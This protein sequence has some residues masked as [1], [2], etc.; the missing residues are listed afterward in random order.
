MAGF[1]RTLEIRSHRRVREAGAGEPLPDPLHLGAGQRRFRVTGATLVDQD[2][3]AVVSLGAGGESRI[4]RGVSEVDAKSE[5][6]VGCRVAT[7]GLDPGD[8]QPDGA[9]LWLRSVLK[10]GEV[11]ARHRAQHDGR[12]VFRARRLSERGPETLL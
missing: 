4:V 9:A 12:D 11:P 7:G 3:L 10:D 5:H 6:R 1:H 2:E 8:E